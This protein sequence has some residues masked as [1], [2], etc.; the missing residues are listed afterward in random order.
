M[1]ISPLLAVLPLA[2]AALVAQ[3]ATP[4][5]G[6]TDAPRPPGSTVGSPL[7]LPQISCSAQNTATSMT[8][9][10]TNTSLRLTPAGQSSVSLCNLTQPNGT[11]PP[12]MLIGNLLVPALQPGGKYAWTTPFPYRSSTPPTCQ[13]ANVQPGN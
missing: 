11:A 4:W 9:T 10:L 8:Y 6:S 13:A 7:T 5:A 2:A 3:A 12:C 1:R